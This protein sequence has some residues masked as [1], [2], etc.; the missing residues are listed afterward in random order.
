MGALLEALM[1]GH[2]DAPDLAPENIGMALVYLK[3]IIDC[4]DKE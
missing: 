3:T 4:L 1:Q 2:E